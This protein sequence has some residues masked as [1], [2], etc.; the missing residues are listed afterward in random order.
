MTG[1]RF[2]SLGLS[3]EKVPEGHHI[4]FIYSD[5]DEK[6][7]TMAKFLQEG[8]LAN[9]KVLYLVN[10]IAPDDMRTELCALGV[11]A[12]ASQSAFDMMEAHY[13]QCPGG[14]FA[15]DYMLNVVGEYYRG[16]LREGFAGAR[17]AGEMSWALEEGRT[18]MPELL[19]YEARLND[20][21]LEHPLTTVCQYDARRFSGQ[22]IMDL[23]SVH[24]MAIVKGQLVKNP[25]FV[26]PAKFLQE[27]EARASAS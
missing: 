12:T 8:L 24:P 14:Y 18:T 26:A 3:D 19:G 16:A 4:V 15:P 21:L 13:K 25:Y 1:Q 17:G 5:D 10:D 2:V 11:D 22:V 7:R 27:L 9:E 20:I 23:L 6:K